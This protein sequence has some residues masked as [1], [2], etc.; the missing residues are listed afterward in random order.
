MGLKSTD[1]EGY[2]NQNHNESHLVPVRILLPK[3]QNITSTGKGVKKKELLFIVVGSV[4]SC[5]CY[6]K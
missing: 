5:S 1:H 6:G 2:A 4:N 3:S